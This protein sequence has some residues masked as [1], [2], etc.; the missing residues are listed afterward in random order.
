[1]NVTSELQR[2]MI[3]VVPFRVGH[4]VTV[5]PSCKCAA[6]WP[7]EYVIT[8][9]RWRYQDGSEIDFSIASDDEIVHRH[10]DTDGFR[11][12]DLLPVFR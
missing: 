10:G 1:M 12:A 8:A 4:R 11:A 6:D 3:E 7:G 5:S 2:L 9:M